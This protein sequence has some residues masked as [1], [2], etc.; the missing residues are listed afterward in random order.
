MGTELKIDELEEAEM[1]HTNKVYYTPN[2][3]QGFVKRL[4]VGARNAYNDAGKFGEKKAVKLFRLY[5]YLA[6]LDDCLQRIP[7]EFQWVRDALPDYAEAS[8]RA[9]GSDLRILLR[10]GLIFKSVV[11]L[12]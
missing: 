11:Q 3:L 8:D 5:Q 7:E 9:I 2:N 6:T 1:K 10:T 12:D 4:R